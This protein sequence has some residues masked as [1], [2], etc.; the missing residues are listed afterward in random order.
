MK[1]SNKRHVQLGRIFFWSMMLVVVSALYLAITKS[2]LFLLCVGIFV[3]YQAFAG[4]RSANTKAIPR[5]FLDVFVLIAAFIN[6]LVMLYTGNIVLII[7]AVI[8]IFL[9]L[10]DLRSYY[11]LY[12]QR[13]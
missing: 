3:F 10:N 5:K 9:V 12:R 11:L 7:F 8:S 2:N 1:K 13:E 6:V 4:M